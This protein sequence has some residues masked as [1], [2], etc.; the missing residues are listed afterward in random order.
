M[1]DTYEFTKKHFKELLKHQEITYNLLW[2]LFPPNALVYTTCSNTKKLQ[3]VRY[4]FGQKKRLENGTVYFS[5]K[6][7][8]LD[9][10]GK[11]F[12]DISAELIICKFRGTERITNLPGFPLRYYPNRSRVT[13]RLMNCRRK[14]VSLLGGYH[15]YYHGTAFFIKDNAPFQVSVNSRVII[16]A[17]FFRKINPKYARPCVIE[18]KKPKSSFFGIDEDDSTTSVDEVVSNRKKPLEL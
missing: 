5:L 12:G 10:N 1:E 7:R 18:I 8:Y 6:C 17:I 11:I 3:C 15:R 13:A 2:A 4:D 14:F 9:F 16:D